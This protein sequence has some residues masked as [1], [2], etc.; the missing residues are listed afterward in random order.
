MPEKIFGWLK[1]SFKFMKRKLT[2]VLILYKRA[3]DSC[4]VVVMPVVESGKEE[5]LGGCR[6][7]VHCAGNS[8]CI[9]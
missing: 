5:L 6:V 4:N 8:E 3:S 1:K 9:G 2:S 7:A